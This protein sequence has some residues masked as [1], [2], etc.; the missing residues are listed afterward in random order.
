MNRLNRRP[1]QGFSL[2]EIMVALV[3]ASILALTLIGAQRQ[4]LNLA[5]SALAVW[6]HLNFSQ[7]LM[8]EKPP[9]EQDV[10]T[11]G[12]M[13]WPDREDAQWRFVQE[14][15]GVQFEHNIDFV[16]DFEG[17][18]KQRQDMQDMLEKLQEASPEV[19]KEYFQT[20][21]QGT[22]MSWEWYEAQ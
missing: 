12:W 9:K 19:K 1:A 14:E 4:S 16:H 13:L 2:V 3:V 15:E 11:P 17:L 10:A 5:S 22:T 6:E 21:V 20:K 7:E 18:A 8:L